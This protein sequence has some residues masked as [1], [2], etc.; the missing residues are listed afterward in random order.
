MN[1]ALRGGGDDAAQPPEILRRRDL[2]GQ[3]SDWG[4]EGR[5]GTMPQKFWRFP[6]HQASALNHREISLRSIFEERPVTRDHREAI[7]TGGR[8]DDP[9]GRIAY[10]IP[11][12]E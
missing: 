1:Q 3:N 10:Q 2:R 7:F 9:I 11:G 4:A 5:R 12:Q 6:Q 8:R